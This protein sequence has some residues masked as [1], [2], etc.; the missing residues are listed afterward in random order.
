MRLRD[1][2]PAARVELLSP[3]AQQPGY[4]YL[5]QIAVAT[6]QSVYNELGNTGRAWTIG[7][8]TLNVVSGREDYAINAQNVGKILDIT[9]YDPSNSNWIEQQVPFYDLNQSTERW[10][11]PLGAAGSVGTI[12]GGPHTALRVSFFYKDGREQL[13]ARV[14]P[15]PQD[16]AT[17]RI[18]FSI[19]DW[20][21]DA[22]LDD[23]PLLKQFHS[24][25]TCQIARDA[26]P[27]AVWD[28]DEKLNDSKRASLDKALSRRIELY[29]GQFKMHI[30]SITAPRNSTRHAPYSID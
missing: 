2:L 4:Q 26:L 13:Y 17:Y 18:S 16:S 22:S 23:S 9:T 1:L 30:A 14:R 10:Q 29:F 12:D 6:L 15:T 8:A 3:R 21:T 5:L 28:D 19:G 27:A 24:L 25:F 7:S 20:A 11:M